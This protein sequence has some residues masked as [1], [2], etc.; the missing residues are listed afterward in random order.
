[1]TWQFFYSDSINTWINGMENECH[2][3]RYIIFY[4]WNSVQDYVYSAFYD[5]IVAKQLYRKWSF[6]NR[7][8]YC[9]NSIYLTY[10]K[11]WLI[12]YI[13]WGV[14]IISSQVFGH[15]RLFKGWIQTE[16]CVIPSYRNRETNRDIISF[17]VVPS[18]Q[19]WSVQ[20]KLKHNNVRLF[21]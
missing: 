12:L 13:V 20:P 10:G 18:K 7:F 21:R 8:I 3:I 17:A 19:K 15:L 16:A 9:R 4:L 1:M 11:M 6:Y 14:V 5:T 2:V